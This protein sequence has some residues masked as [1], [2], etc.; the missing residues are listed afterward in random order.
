MGYYNHCNRK[1]KNKWIR[2]LTSDTWL[3]I[4][5]GALNPGYLEL[6]VLDY[7]C[8]HNSYPLLA[9]MFCFH[10]DKEISCH[11]GWVVII[12]L[13]LILNKQRTTKTENRIGN[14]VLL[15]REGGM[16]LRQNAE[17]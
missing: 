6:L 7:F 9:I 11:W 15:F 10:K 3:L 13:S 1:Q 12:F 5:S 14:Q 17:T 4:Q 8:G 2:N 16:L